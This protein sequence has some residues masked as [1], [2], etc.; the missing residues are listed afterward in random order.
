MLN[1]QPT[2]LLLG[3]LLVLGAAS[4]TWLLKKRE[5]ES[6]KGH[7]RTA[8]AVGKGLSQ[9]GLFVTGEGGR[10][11]FLQGLPSGTSLVFAA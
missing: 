3:Q 8:L 5:E 2:C 6:M 1:A 7:T 11:Q 10:G 4:L 9:K